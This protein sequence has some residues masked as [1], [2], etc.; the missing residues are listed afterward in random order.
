MIVPRVC[1]L[2]TIDSSHN[3][4]LWKEFLVQFIKLNSSVSGHI[5]AESINLTCV[6]L[7]YFPYV[8]YYFFAHIEWIQLN[9]S[10]FSWMDGRGR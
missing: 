1:L 7:S 3:I 2:K 8:E 9:S 5:A 6:V 4:T 10:G